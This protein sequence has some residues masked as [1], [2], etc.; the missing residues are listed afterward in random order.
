M[1]L[2]DMK[3][4]DTYY[5]CNIA[6]NLIYNAGIDTASTLASFFERHLEIA[7]SNF[8]KYSALHDYCNWVVNVL[9]FQEDSK[10]I[11]ALSDEVGEFSEYDTNELLTKLEDNKATI[12]LWFDNA[13]N[14]YQPEFTSFYEWLIKNYE[15]YMHLDCA[16]DDYMEK[17]GEQ[18]SYSNTLDMISLEMFYVLFENRYFLYRFNE[19][20]ADCHEYEIPRV[21]VP[22]WAKRAVFYR[23]K[24]KCVLCHKDLSGLLDVSEGRGIQYDHIVPLENGGLNDISNLQLLCDECNQRKGTTAMTGTSYRYLYDI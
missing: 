10:R 20:M 24:G 22:Q 19:Y 12:G 16:L 17:I 13:I 21:Y 4:F 1:S 2:I 5:F 11:Y 7:P 6:S 14:C 18:E 23:D 15:D 3:F 8:E 9:F